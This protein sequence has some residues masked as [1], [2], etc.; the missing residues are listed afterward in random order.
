MTDGIPFK[1]HTCASMGYDM[2]RY[3][4][5]GWTVWTTS[6]VANGDYGTIHITAVCCERQ[7]LNA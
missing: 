2:T 4:A 7:P 1:I 3:Q 6:C 5:C